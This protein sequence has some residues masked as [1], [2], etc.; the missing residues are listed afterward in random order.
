MCGIISV[1][2]REGEFLDE[3]QN[4]IQYGLSQLRS[5]GYDAIG[6]VVCSKTRHMVCKSA[7]QNTEDY[8]SA[9]HSILHS[10]PFARVAM[11]HTRWRT[12]GNNTD[13]NAHP[14]SSTDDR[15]H[16][17]HNGIIE[18]HS[19]LRRQLCSEGYKFSSQTDSEV[20]VA[21]FSKFVSAG[22]SV[23]ESFCEAVSLLTGSWAITAVDA[24]NS[25]TLF[26]ANNGSPL[27]IGIG[28][29]SVYVSSEYQ[30][31]P[32]GRGSEMT[33]RAIPNNTVAMIQ[34]GQVRTREGGMVPIQQ[35]CEERC[36]AL[37]S[38]EDDEV[39]EEKTCEFWVHHEI[40]SQGLCLDRLFSMKTALCAQL[41]TLDAMHVL[42]IG[43][44]TSL[45]ACQFASFSFRDSRRFHSAQVVDAA[46]FD[47]SYLTDDMLCILVSQSGETK[48]CLDVLQAID[49]D[50]V[51]R[52]VRVIGVINARNSQMSRK[53]EHTVLTYAGCE[54]AVASTKVFTCQV[55]I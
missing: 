1:L 3:T 39:G 33:I 48:D 4:D 47:V 15:L 21:L 54:H 32:P 45:H 17:V 6:V 50:S 35:F 40:H 9:V 13:A 25:D 41:P 36:V 22:N 28:E 2:H 10:L 53:M 23:Y 24:Q 49:Q 16:I 30:A 37:A 8:E 42:L 27:M 29:S 7:I 20:I 46:A 31:I 18:N 5:R 12:H 38:T 34:S 55:Y 26:V 14:F 52:R 51:N 11:A 19:E 44:G 43:C